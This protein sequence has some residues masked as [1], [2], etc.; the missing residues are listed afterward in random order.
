MTLIILVVMSLI[1][2]TVYAREGESGPLHT[3]QL[4][5]AEVLRPL[6]SVASTIVKPIDALGTMAGNVLDKNNAE[7]SLKKKKIQNKEL[8][9][10]NVDLEQENERLRQLVNGTKKSYT[11]SPLAQVV[12]PIGGQFTE[13]IVI[14]VGSDDGVKPEQ[15]VVV[16]K[17]TFV[18]RTTG[19]VTAHTAEVMLITDQNFQA[20][21]RILPH[22]TGKPSQK[23]PAAGG[24]TTGETTMETTTPE[25]TNQET[26]TGTSNESTAEG[27]LGT[28]SEGYLGVELVDVSASVSQGDYVVTSGR[29]GDRRLL[30]P[31]GLLAGTVES[32][33]QQDID[34]YK[35]I[36]VTPAVQ[37]DELQ[38]VRVITNW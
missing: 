13:R 14:N 10:Q 5:A 19:R 33:A 11:Y 15:A 27:L 2:F 6:R 35:K 3:V 12:A 26:T 4:G 22:A 37:P 36:V 25:R 8:A 31:P 34:Q 18:G 20:G 21:V 16:G 30:F 7:Q 23:S 17:N 24:S 1:L 38:E 32:V 28:T 9:A 29:A